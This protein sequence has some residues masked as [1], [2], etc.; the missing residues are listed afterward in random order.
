[1]RIPG[2]TDGA[3]GPEAHLTLLAL[4]GLPHEHS[5]TL[6]CT[7]DASRRCVSDR[8]EDRTSENRSFHETDLPPDHLSP[9]TQEPCLGGSLL[10]ELG[11]VGRSEDADRKGL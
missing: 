10:L 2:S 8:D 6:P 1:S 3:I 9:V 11:A 4:A 5:A 7:Q